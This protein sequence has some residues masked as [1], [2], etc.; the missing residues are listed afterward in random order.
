MERPGDCH[1][2]RSRSEREKQYCIMSLISGTGEIICKREIE[3]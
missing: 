2:E 1:V 3:T